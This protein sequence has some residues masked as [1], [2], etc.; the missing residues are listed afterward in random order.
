MHKTYVLGRL[1]YPYFVYSFH[2]TLIYI[3]NK[4]MKG[5]LFKV[6]IMKLNFRFWNQ[7]FNHIPT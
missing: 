6:F 2:F 4:M 3:I 7:I 1:S 5:I